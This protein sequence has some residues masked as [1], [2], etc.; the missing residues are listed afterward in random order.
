MYA[1]APVASTLTL[2]HDGIYYQEHMEGVVNHVTVLK[3]QCVD[4]VPIKVKFRAKVNSLVA[5]FSCDLTQH[6]VL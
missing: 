4:M 3:L 2:S 5:D 1:L 6:F